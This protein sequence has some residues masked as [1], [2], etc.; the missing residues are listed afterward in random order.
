[1]AVSFTDRKA[2]LIRCDTDLI[3]IIWYQNYTYIY[4]PG[5]MNVTHYMYMLCLH[6]CTTPFSQDWLINFT[7]AHKTAGRYC[8][9]SLYCILYWYWPLSGRA[10]LHFIIAIYMCWIF[11]SLRRIFVSLSL[12]T[13]NRD[14]ETA[15]NIWNMNVER[16]RRATVFGLPKM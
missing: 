2:V 4:M 5:Y 9:V 8:N 13:Y 10:P 7:H 6:A 1:M 14:N 11:A 16:S 12:V 3:P 15:T